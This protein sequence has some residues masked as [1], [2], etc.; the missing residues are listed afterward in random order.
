M[1]ELLINFLISMTYPYYMA[2]SVFSSVPYFY[3]SK[4]PTNLTMKMASKELIFDE[5][6]SSDSSFSL[7]FRKKMFSQM[8]RTA[9]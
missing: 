4:Y 8:P 3:I 9:G 2:K 1:P 7:W 6:S 5:E